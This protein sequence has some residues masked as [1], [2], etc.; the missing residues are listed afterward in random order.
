MNHV[1][2]HEQ[3]KHGQQSSTRLVVALSVTLVVLIVEIIGG[4]ISGSVGL[5]ADA[6]HMFIDSSG[7]IVALIAS[8]IMLRPRNDI[9]TWGW[10]RIEIIA[11]G[12][13]AGMLFLI[14]LWVAYH[15]IGRL[16]SPVSLEFTPMIIAASVG[17]LANLISLSVLFGGRASSLN[18]KAAFLEVLNDAL[19][20]VAV[21]VAALGYYFFDWQRA[22][23]IAAL[24]VAGLMA[25]RAILLLRSAVRILLEASPHDVD[26]ADIRKHFATLPYVANVHDV[27]VST[28]RT[29]VLSLTAH[30]AIVPQTTDDQRGQL[31]HRLEACAQQHFQVPILHSTFQLEQEIHGSHENSQH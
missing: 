19:G 28:I 3:G 21:I 4:I 1:H 12:V 18:M 8:R 20:S 6:G 29:G 15:A 17:L 13:Q 14:C 2:S 10:G 11:A 23:G 27:H 16:F 30:I 24:L 25:P 31:L 7:L 9:Y 5:L 26:V 22:D